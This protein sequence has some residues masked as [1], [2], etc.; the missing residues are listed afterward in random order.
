MSEG[1]VNVPPAP[2]PRRVAV[3]MEVALLAQELPDGR[4][5]YGL[6]FRGN[7]EDEGEAYRALGMAAQAVAQVAAQKAQ[8]KRPRPQILMPD[9]SRPPFPD[10]PLGEKG[11]S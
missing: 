11:E 1:T 8:K 9:G 2:P 6:E 5:C 4:T 10:M 3:R 7:F